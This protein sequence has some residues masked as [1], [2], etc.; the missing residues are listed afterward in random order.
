MVRCR[1]KNELVRKI[2]DVQ[3]GINFHPRQNDFCPS[4][5]VL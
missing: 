3:N 1:G 2:L 4:S 5:A